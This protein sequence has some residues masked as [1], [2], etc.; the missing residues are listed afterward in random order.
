MLDKITVHRIV[1]LAVK[2][3]N[4]FVNILVLTF[5]SGYLLSMTNPSVYLLNKVYVSKAIVET[6]PELCQKGDFLL[7]KKN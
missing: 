7:K 1:Y 5:F 4:I 2:K 6:G 3:G